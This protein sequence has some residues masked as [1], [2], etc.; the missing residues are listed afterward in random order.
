[1]ENK[2]RCKERYYYYKSRGICTCC[3]HDLAMYGSTLCPDC[4][5]KSEIATK[6]CR[7]KDKDYKKKDSEAHKRLTERREA[8]GL[9][10]RCGKRPPEKGYKRCVE[11]KV[12]RRKAYLKSL[13]SNMDKTELKQHLDLCR[14]CGNANLV[15]GKKVCSKCYERTTKQAEYARSFCNRDNHYWRDLNTMDFGGK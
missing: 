13:N 8:L 1:M 5:E 4:S 11:C 2:E 15:Q 3:G 14:M 7:D 9:C 6:K 10:N 12:K